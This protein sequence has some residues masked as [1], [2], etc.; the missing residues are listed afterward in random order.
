[1]LSGCRFLSGLR[2]L[3]NRQTTF[4]QVQGET[5]QR[6]TYP[7]RGAPPLHRQR[8]GGIRGAQHGLYRH[9][10]HLRLFTEIA[11][12]KRGYAS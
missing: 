4:R 6:G 7:L 3:G 2:T 1:M 8:L 11:V 10:V 9:G 12:G 5:D